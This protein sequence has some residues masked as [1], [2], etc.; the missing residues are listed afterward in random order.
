MNTID[1]I[2]TVLLV[3]GL[4]L[5]GYACISFLKI[6]KTRKD[7]DLTQKEYKYRN[8]SAILGVLGGILLLIAFIIGI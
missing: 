1:I 4:A 3:A 7:R 5:S 6:E 8:I 2:T